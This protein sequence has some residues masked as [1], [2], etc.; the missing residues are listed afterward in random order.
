MEDGGGLV[1]LITGVEYLKE[2]ITRVESHHSLKNAE[3]ARLLR[4]IG[5]MSREIG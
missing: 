2:K 1:R 5:Y 3:V 4:W